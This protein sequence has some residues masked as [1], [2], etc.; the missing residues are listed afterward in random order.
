MNDRIVS[1]F[2]KP[3]IKKY[4]ARWYIVRRD[5][6]HAYKVLSFGQARYMVWRGLMPDDYVRLATLEAGACP[7]ELSYSYSEV[8]AHGS[9]TRSGTRRC[10]E[11]KTIFSPRGH[12]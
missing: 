7:H 11:C 12:A 8:D 3:A 6:G 2:A 5:L 10:V 1:R 4:G 9:V